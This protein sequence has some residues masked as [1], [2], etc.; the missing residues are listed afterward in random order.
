MKICIEDLGE[1]WKW[2]WKYSGKDYWTL[3]LN[4][5]VSFRLEYFFPQI[6]FHIYLLE[7]FVDASW[8]VI[9]IVFNLSFVQFQLI[10]LRYSCHHCLLQWKKGTLWNGWKRRVSSALLIP[11]LF[12]H[13]CFFLICWFTQYMIY[14]KWLVLMLVNLY[15]LSKNFL[16]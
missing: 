15:C 12:D 1:R 16:W 6:E 14:M 9:L 4:S 2:N 5:W 11:V 13:F 8:G 3:S 7:L 10:L